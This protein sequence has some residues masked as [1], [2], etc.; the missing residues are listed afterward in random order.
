VEFEE[1]PD[2]VKRTAELLAQG[3]IIG[4]AQGRS[5]FGPRA[6]GNRSILADPR[7]AENKD[8]IN[9][10]VKKREGFR[11]F[12]PSV[13]EERLD[14]Y[15]EAPPKKKQFSYMVF[16]MKVR[17]EMRG[18]L[19]AVTHV[20][21][22]ARI[23]TVSKQTNSRFWDVIN[24]FGNLTGVYVLLNT[25]FNNNVEPIVDS[26]DDAIICFLTTNLPYLVIGDFIVAKKNN[27]P[28][29]YL[30]LIPSIPL[31]VTVSQRKEYIS[32][33]DSRFVFEMGN[34]YD[35]QFKVKLSP[36]AFSLLTSANGKHSIADLIKAAGIPDE[37]V[38]T[39]V[40]ELIELWSKRLINLNP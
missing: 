40:G 10:M 32:T 11:P 18:I 7:P 38:S 5:E 6:L 8:I 17:K 39:V 37:M 1:S 31:Y 25:S 2:V 36:E 12:A 24:E 19:G 27:G 21:G 13:I 29:A 28:A 30:N 34:N 9:E 14:E 3:G 26:P 22:T 23:H 4:W 35:D 20:D 15:F 16:V 33:R